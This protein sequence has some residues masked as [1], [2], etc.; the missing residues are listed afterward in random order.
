MS[1]RARNGLWHCKKSK[2]RNRIIISAPDIGGT[3]VPV[4]DRGTEI[5]GSGSVMR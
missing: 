4:K 5:M 3:H 1:R 2:R